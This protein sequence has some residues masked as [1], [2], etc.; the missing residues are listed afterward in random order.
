[1]TAAAA[2]VRTSVAAVVAI[3]CG[4]TGSARA[5]DPQP[6]PA[7]TETGKHCRGEGRTKL[8]A[9]DTLLGQS[10]PLGVENDL[11]VAVCT[12]LIREPGLLFDY[13]N[14]QAGVLNYLAPVYVH[15][16]VFVSLAPLSLLELRAEAAG[17][18]IWPLPLFDAAGY[19]SV[20][21]YR[22]RFDGAALPASRARASSGATASLTATL[23]G[24]VEL[25]NGIGLIALDALT[26]EYWWV[27]GAP[28]YY[29]LRRDLVLARSDSLL[30]NMVLLSLELAL[31]R[32][33]L[34][35]L[36]ATDDLF[37]V[38]AAG[39]LANIAAGFGSVVLRDWPQA[40][41]E[42]Q[43]FIRAGVFTHHRVRSGLQLLGGL[44]TSFDLLP[45]R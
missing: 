36:G 5:D 28:Y 26:W 25:G 10:A 18:A 40:G 45:R 7:A 20:A 16:G 17:V 38:P 2:A 23:Q 31:R 12:P 32:D 42:L 1:M 41:V 33:L 29:N 37:Y 14:L 8:I 27:S 19:F 24:Q 13:T 4:L 21:D 44:S 11:A 3:A 15:Q 43:P 34:L 6:A 9:S 35:R 30:E 22:A 39:Y